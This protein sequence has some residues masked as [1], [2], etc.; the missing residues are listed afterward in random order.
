MPPAEAGATVPQSR[1]PNRRGRGRR[2]NSPHPDEPSNGTGP[3]PVSNSGG[4]TN[5]GRRRNR[6]PRQEG[7]GA[8]ASETH[9]LPPHLAT[10]IQ[11]DISA[12]ESTGS[13][14]Q[15]RRGRGGR[16]NRSSNRGTQPGRGGRR[17]QFGA[18]LTEGSSQSTGPVSEPAPPPPTSGDLTS[19]LIYSL[20]H[21]HDAVDCPICFN[22]VHPTQ[23]IWSCAPPS[24]LV[25]DTPATCCWTIFH[26]KCIKEWA[27]KSVEA[28]REA[29]RARN[30]DLP[31][32][33]RCPGCQTKRTSVPQA[34]TCFCARAT[35]P[36]PSQLSTPHSCGEPCA[37]VRRE[38]EH[39]CPMACH[40]GPCPPCLVSVSKDCW[41]GNKT[42]VSRCSTLNKAT[43]NGPTTAPTLSCG[44]PCGKLLG[45]EKHT[46]QV[47]CHPG[48]CAPCQVVDSTRCYCG[49]HEKEMPCG[50][51]AP[52]EC[53]VSGEG[54]WEGR[55]Q[56]EEICDR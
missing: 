39:A 15:S 31:G 42:I 46:C 24:T 49:K 28:T 6:Q 23:S 10:E 41:C 29:Y 13:H 52:M 11:G 26:M 55:W 1:R 30:V 32:E 5:R 20:T 27:R 45:C 37:R 8:A 12:A 47:E 18:R 19:R 54:T 3:T 34:Y 35:N 51:G 44:Q 2:N 14:T 21:K 48:P 38:C 7:S 36:T 16:G 4:S 50:T 9:R 17:Q 22:P 56:C 25:G 40:P 33:W 43:P 53:S